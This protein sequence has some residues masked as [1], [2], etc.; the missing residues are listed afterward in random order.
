MGARRQFGDSPLCGPRPEVWF[1][2]IAGNIRNGLQLWCQV[3]D[4]QV[5]WRA[6]KMVG[7]VNRALA[8]ANLALLADYPPNRRSIGHSSLS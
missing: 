4:D 6:A 3:P 8:G 7:D 1:D 2:P 5:A